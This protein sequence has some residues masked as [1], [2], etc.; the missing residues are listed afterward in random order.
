MTVNL[1]T[2]AA[3]YGEMLDAKIAAHDGVVTFEDMFAESARMTFNARRTVSAAKVVTAF[4]AESETRQ[5][6]LERIGFKAYASETSV[7]LH[8]MVGEIISTLKD[9]ESADATPSKV[10]TLVANAIRSLPGKTGDVQEWIKACQTDGETVQTF[11][12]VLR[13][14]VNSANVTAAAVKRARDL[15]A[16]E[17]KAAAAADASKV[18]AGLT[19]PTSTTVEVVI[20]AEVVPA[21]EVAEVAEVVPAEIGAPTSADLLAVIQRA[22]DMLAA[23]APVTSEIRAGIDML[24]DMAA[25]PPGLVEGRGARDTRERYAAGRGHD[26]DGSR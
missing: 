1:K 15:K 10:Q 6:D 11:L 20:P 3:A 18:L 9:A 7:N 24:A 21:A 19:E 16:A 22:L 12:D 4:A 2:A 8:A 26:Q 25:D 17:D 23:G 14:D 13:Q 5:A